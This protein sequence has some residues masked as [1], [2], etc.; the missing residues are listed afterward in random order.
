MSEDIIAKANHCVTGQ[1]ILCGDVIRL[2]HMETAKNLHSHVIQSPLSRKNEVSAYGDD[3]EGD[4]LDNWIV[5]CIDKTT[6]LMI[7]SKDEIRGTSVI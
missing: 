3:G 1:P 4:R 7:N 2:E 6:G 5:E